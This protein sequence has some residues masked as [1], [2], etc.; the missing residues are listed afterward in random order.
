MLKATSQ[1]LILLVPLIVLS[2]LV[3]QIAGARGSVFIIEPA[4][5]ITEKVS[6]SVNSEVFGNLSVID[7]YPIDFWITSPSG[8]TVLRYAEI[9]NDSFNFATNENGFY[10][11]HLNNTYVRQNVTVALV[12]VVNFKAIIQENVN[13]GTSVGVAEVVPPTTHPELPEIDDPRSENLYVKYLNFLG[14][15]GILRVLREGISYLPICDLVLVTYC[16][17]LVVGSFEVIKHRQP[18]TSG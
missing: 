13:V 2:G 4:K 7:G 9:V 16:L 6:L 17:A 11:M 14:S 18:A 8:T 1:R 12:W 10:T 3:S 15:Y 5:E